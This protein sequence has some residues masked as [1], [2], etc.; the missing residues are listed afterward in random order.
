MQS[1]KYFS[2]K[3]FDNL[4]TG[5]GMNLARHTASTEWPLSNIAGVSSN[6]GRRMCEL[7]SY[8]RVLLRF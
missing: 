1:W 3:L 2:G 6:K 5:A 8:R 7:Y 4:E